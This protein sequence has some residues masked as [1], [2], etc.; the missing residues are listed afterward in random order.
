MDNISH[1]KGLLEE[2]RSKIQTNKIIEF[3]GSDVE[4]MKALM[5]FFLDRKWEW[6]YNQWA[7]WPVGFI[8]RKQPELIYPYFDEMIAM[9]DNP[10]HDAVI[11]NIIRI[12]E[13]IEIPENYEGGIYDRCFKF[14]NDPNQTIAVRCFSMKVVFNISQKYPELQD[15]LEASIKLHL[16]YGSAGFKSRG[17]RFLNILQKKK[18]KS[19]SK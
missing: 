2:E 13:V 17:N 18:D 3:V 4:R 10:T 8:G 15:E 14:L 16:P 19:K 7:A 1:I 11:R 6:R 12:L 9:M 5:S